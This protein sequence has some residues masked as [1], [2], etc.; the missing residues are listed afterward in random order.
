MFTTLLFTITLLQNQLVSMKNI[1][2]M[3]PTIREQDLPLQRKE[4]LH[5]G[6]R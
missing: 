1:K 5:S 3:C 2:G 4:L 6:Q